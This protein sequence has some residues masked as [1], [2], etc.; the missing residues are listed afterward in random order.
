MLFKRPVNVYRP[1]ELERMDV[2][3]NTD[4]FWFYGQTVMSV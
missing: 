4:M 2:K 1:L 3:A